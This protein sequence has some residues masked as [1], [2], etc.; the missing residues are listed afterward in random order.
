METE[1]LVK[2]RQVPG[3]DYKIYDTGRIIGASEGKETQYVIVKTNSL[4]QYHGQPYAKERYIKD[5]KEVNR[6]NK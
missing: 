6:A 5:L 1:A 2:G 4:G 3:K